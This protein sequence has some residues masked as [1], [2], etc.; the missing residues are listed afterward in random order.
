MDELINKLNNMDLNKEISDDSIDSLCES[1]CHLSINPTINVQQAEIEH[2]VSVIAKI[3]INPIQIKKL[4]IIGV[5]IS[6]LMKK[7]K[8]YEFPDAYKIPKYIY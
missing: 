5:L 7:I 6:N 8:Y 4:D 1:L 2:V 3:Q